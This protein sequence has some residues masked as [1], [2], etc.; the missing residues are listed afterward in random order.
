MVPCPTFEI[1]S[2]DTFSC[3]AAQYLNFDAETKLI[4]AVRCSRNPATNHFLAVPYIIEPD[5]Q[6]FL[7]VPYIINPC[8]YCY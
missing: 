4:L 6:V 1:T 7:A 2:S 3:S 8:L 5:T